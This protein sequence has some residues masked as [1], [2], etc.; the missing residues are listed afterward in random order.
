MS[1]CRYSQGRA[2]S[3]ELLRAVVVQMAAH[4]AALNPMTFAVWYE[5]LAGINPSLSAALDKCLRSAGRLDDQ[6]IAGLHR[7]HVAEIDPALADRVGGDVERVMLS[8]ADSAASTGQTVQG[9]DT[10]LADLES[11]LRAGDPQG[12]EPQLGATLAG[13][14]QMRDSVESLRRAAIASQEELQQL[15][16]ELQR[17]RIEAVTDPL[18]RLL[19]RKGFDQQLAGVLAE[20]PPHGMAHCLAM[21]DLDHFKRINDTHGHLVGDSV[22]QALGDILRR[23]TNGT[24]A[25][26]ARY[27]GEEFAILL[28]ATT[29]KAAVNLAQSVCALARAA[30]VRS[31]CT[32]EV[33]ATVTVSTGIAAWQPGEQATGLIASA[34]AA[35]Y[36]SKE[37]GRDRVTVA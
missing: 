27:G 10:Q 17:S 3:A 9:Y 13:T 4:P 21:F 25:A 2:Q 29:V 35:L 8:I 26:C 5:H 31:R 6:A 16:A 1:H 14:R 34:D 28:P 24:D 33:I 23:A 18:T 36:R 22:L 15:R 30:R 19:N 32:Q 37:M 12:V 20:R 7:D 11:A